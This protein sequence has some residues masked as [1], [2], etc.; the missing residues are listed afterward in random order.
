MNKKDM[1]Y[2]KIRKMDAQKLH[3][4]FFDPWPHPARVPKREITYIVMDTLPTK[5]MLL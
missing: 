3:E 5:T 1:N 2:M 4:F